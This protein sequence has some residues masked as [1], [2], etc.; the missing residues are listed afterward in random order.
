MCP[1][2]GDFGPWLAKSRQPHL[3]FSAEPKDGEE[4]ELGLFHSHLQGLE[5]LDRGAL[6]E[7]KEDNDL[8]PYALFNQDSGGLEN[9]VPLSVSTPLYGSP[10]KRTDS[11]SLPVG[12]PDADGGAEGLDEHNHDRENDF[13]PSLGENTPLTLEEDHNQNLEDNYGGLSKDLEDLERNLS[14]SLHV[15]NAPN[16]AGPVVTENINTVASFS[17][18]EFWFY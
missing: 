7:T 10:P 17:D 6:S 16:S 15:S 8:F 11:D 5:S 2:F 18:D 14:E 3:P 4:T 12:S 9:V 13:P 1:P